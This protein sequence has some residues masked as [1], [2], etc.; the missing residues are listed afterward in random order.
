MISRTAQIRLSDGTVIFQTDPFGT[1][2][3]VKKA[4]YQMIGRQRGREVPRLVAGRRVLL[5]QGR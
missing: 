3:Q 4:T 2:T 5:A 1:G